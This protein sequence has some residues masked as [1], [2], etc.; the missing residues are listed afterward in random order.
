[1]TQQ[2]QKSRAQDLEPIPFLAVLEL[3]HVQVFAG[4]VLA[5][6]LILPRLFSWAG[7]VMSC[8]GTWA[9]IE[10]RRRDPRSQ[11]S[12]H[13]LSYQLNQ[14][15]DSRL[16]I[17]DQLTQIEAQGAGSTLGSMR[18][19]VDA[20]TERAYRVAIA[21]KTLRSE[22][23]VVQ[24]DQELS[25]LDRRLAL[26]GDGGE[27]PHLDRVRVQLVRERQALVKR[28]QMAQKLD[29]EIMTIHQFL[30][31][32][33]TELRTFAARLQSGLTEDSPELIGET[34]DILDSIDEVER[35]LDQIEDGGAVD[36]LAA[37]GITDQASLAMVAQETPEELVPAPV[38]E[39]VVPA[40]VAD[41]TPGRVVPALASVPPGTES[42]LRHEIET[43]LAA[44]DP[45]GVVSP[46][47]LASTQK[48]LEELQ[49]PTSD[50]QHLAQVLLDKASRPTDTSSTSPK[51]VFLDMVRAVFAD[52]KITGAENKALV[53][54]AGILGL[55][56]K[57][58]ELLARQARSELK[59][60]DAAS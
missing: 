2:L 16:S 54:L 1:M 53:S 49:L 20:M 39:G 40:L 3:H 42:S 60:G 48:F 44:F 10:S 6:I 22:R 5:S 38:P 21:M 8:I 24:L 46:E 14:I 36:P 33:D 43:W 35:A 29:I 19:K 17:N 37:I 15:E 9:W 26:A 50:A 34:R 18:A 58:C 28:D 7:I 4:A 51:E 12:Y 59:R 30:Q 32:T 27:R 57:E 55:S 11:V 31:S 56:R 47:R 13:G 25:D 41:E 23:S 45:T 52:R